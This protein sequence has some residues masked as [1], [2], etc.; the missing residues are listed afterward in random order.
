MAKRASAD[1]PRTLAKKRQ[2]GEAKS[3]GLSPHGRCISEWESWRQLHG[4]QAPSQL[5]EDIEEKRLAKRY[6]NVP[7]ARKPDA[8]LQCFA[9]A[10]AFH[11][12]WGVLP[13]QSEDPGRE[14][15]RKLALE[16]KNRRRAKSLSAD[17][18]QLL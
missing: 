10:V 16:L 6:A 12:T 17:A 7:R 8:A 3:S 9:K 18:K 15:E 2:R 4:G 5:S 11:E 1:A 13:Q 14:E